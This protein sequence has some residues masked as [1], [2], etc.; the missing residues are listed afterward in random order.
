MVA[1]L[2]WSGVAPGTLH[3]TAGPK[4]KSKEVGL[5]CDRDN[6]SLARPQGPGRSSACHLDVLQLGPQAGGGTGAPGRST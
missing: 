6:G 4:T 5:L 3:P 2:P 1:R